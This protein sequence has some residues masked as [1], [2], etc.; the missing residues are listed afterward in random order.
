MRGPNKGSRNKLCRNKLCQ[1]VSFEYL[2]HIWIGRL[3]LAYKVLSIKQP[4]HFLN[5]LLRMSHSPRHSKT[6][7]VFPCRTEYFKNT[8]FLNDIMNGINL[9]QTFI[10]LINIFYNALLKFIRP[11]ER[12]ICSV[13]DPFRIKMLTRLRSVF[14]HMHEHKLKHCIK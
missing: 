7:N 8:S 11:V 4:S 5:L 1:G 13:N 6:I 10:A 3:Y 9:I 12:K 2:H 14:R